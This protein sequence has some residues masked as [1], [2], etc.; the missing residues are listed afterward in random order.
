MAFKMDGLDDLMKELEKV[1]NIEDYAPELLNA[2]APILEKTLKTEVAAAANRGYASGNLKKSITA[3]KPSKNKIG[4]YVS[5]TAKG[6]DKSGTR[7][8]EK[9][10]YLNY[11]TSKQ[12]ARPVLAKAVRK[13]EDECV[14]SMQKK[15]DEVLKL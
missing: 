14:E 4:Y 12:S 2:A 15:L 6:K 11:G 9:L 5:V 7:N 10:A 8:N 1:G 13:A 3:N